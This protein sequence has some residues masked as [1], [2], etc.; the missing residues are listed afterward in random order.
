MDTSFKKQN[1][2]FVTV[3][4]ACF[5]AHAEDQL[6]DP[7]VQKTLRN[8]AATTTWYHPDQFGEFSGMRHYAHREFEGAMRDF[9]SG[10]YYADKMSQL[11]IGLMYLNGEGVAKDPVTAYAWLDLAA[12]RHYPEFVATRDRVKNTLS[13][14]QLAAAANVRDQLAQTYGDAVAK[15][16]MIEQLR[17]GQM[18]M[19]GSHTGFDSGIHDATTGTLAGSSPRMNAATAPPVGC[20]SIN[21]P[22]CWEPKEYFAHR[23]AA[24]NATVSVG[25]VQMQD[26]KSKPSGGAAESH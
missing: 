11:S 26:D 9:K 2:V 16:R 6:N 5:G 17:L 4:L 25:D 15:P 24:W 8:M 1:V 14:T 22:S 21:S 3:L 12:E 19:T 13:P 10:A 18:Q 7:V 23:D 20:S